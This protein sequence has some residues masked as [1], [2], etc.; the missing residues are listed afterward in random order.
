MYSSYDEE[1]GRGIIHWV[2]TPCSK[3]LSDSGTCPDDAEKLRPWINDSVDY[4]FVVP[5]EHKHKMNF[6]KGLKVVFDLVKEGEL[7]VTKLRF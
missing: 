4:F 3:P 2:F 7:E 5:P 6:K 1:E